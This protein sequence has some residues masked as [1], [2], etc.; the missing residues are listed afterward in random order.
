MKKPFLTTDRL[1][2]IGYAAVSIAYAVLFYVKYRS[3]SAK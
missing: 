2:L 1:V 3:K